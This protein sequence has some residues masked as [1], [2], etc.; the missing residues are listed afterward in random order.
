[1]NNIIFKCFNCLKPF[2]IDNSKFKNINRDD[3]SC[4]CPT[5]YYS[6]YNQIEIESLTPDEEYHITYIHNNLS[7]HIKKLKE[8]EVGKV[9]IGIHHQYN[10]NIN[11]LNMKNIMSIINTIILN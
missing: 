7:L 11:D 4:N 1:M 3:C 10:I 2:T 5:S 6:F 8:S 9:Y